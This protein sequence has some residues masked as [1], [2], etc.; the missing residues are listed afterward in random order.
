MR[1][2]ARA[3][4]YFNAASEDD[5]VMFITAAIKMGWNTER[6]IVGKLAE[7]L[8]RDKSKQYRTAEIL[9]ALTGDD[10][11]LHRWFR[12]KSGRHHLLH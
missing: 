7:M 6:D 10:P 2:F 5:V 12:D 3:K 11:E 1:A 9:E 4:E 8:G